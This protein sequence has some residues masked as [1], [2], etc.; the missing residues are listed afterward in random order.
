MPEEHRRRSDDQWHI[1]K[2]LDV[3]HI[4]TTIILC[5][6][7]LM[8][9]TNIDKRLAIVEANK[10]VQQ[11]IRSDIREI[12]NVLAPLPE[13]IER[14]NATDKEQWESIRALEKE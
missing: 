11:E 9:I 6:G 2:T 10:E 14:K 7:G 8:Y 13:F 12:K 1:G 4:I 5:V 3:G